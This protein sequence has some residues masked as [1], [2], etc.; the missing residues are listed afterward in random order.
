V[1]ADPIS[2]GRVELGIG[3]GWM[4]LE[5][6]AYG[7]PFPSMGMR[8]D[9]LA[10]QL[11]IIAGSFADGPFSFRGEHWSVEELDALPKPVQRPLPLLMGG[12]A[13]ARGAALAARFAGEYNV[14]H[15]GPDDAAA[16]RRRL[17]A[18][19]ERAGRDP[20]TLRFSLMHGFLV[21]TGEEDLRSRAARLA[22][23]QGEPADVD[24]LR[25]DW[26]AGTPAEIVERLREYEAAGVERVMFQHLLHRDTEALELLAA[27][28]LPAFA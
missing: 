2:G 25:R 17:A 8:M 20:A 19:C 4:E 21:G 26:I 27:E 24:A 15:A 12:G 18:A 3:T 28:V 23:W 7:F 13:K 22:E 9:R 16:S 1:T 6:R 14:V 10:E 11:E 5:H